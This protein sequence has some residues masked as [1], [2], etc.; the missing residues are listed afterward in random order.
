MPV[1]IGS[2]WKT[3][4][5][6]RDLLLMDFFLFRFVVDN[7]RASLTTSIIDELDFLQQEHTQRDREHESIVSQSVFR[8]LHRYDFERLRSPPE[9]VRISTRTH[10]FRRP[11][12]VDLGGSPSYRLKHSVVGGMPSKGIFYTERVGKW[13]STIRV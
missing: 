13:P 9:N 11:T 6:I 7:V 3:C 1:K 12:V 5:E 10:K 4:Q 2:S 8:R